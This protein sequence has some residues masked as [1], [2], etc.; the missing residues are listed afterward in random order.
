MVLLV[1]GM[2]GTTFLPGVVAAMATFAGPHTDSGLD[3]DGD[4]LF[5]YLVVQASIDVTE[6]G[7]FFV[8]GELH[9]EGFTFGVSASNVTTLA[10]GLQTVSLWFF[11]PEINASGVDGPYLVELYLN[12]Y[13]AL[14]F[15]AN[16]THTT[17]AYSHLDFEGPPASL[18][19]PHADFGLDTDA[20]GRFNQLVV[21]VTVNVTDAGMFLIAGFLHNANYS[22]SLST[23][24][25][26][27]LPVGVQTVPLWFQGFSIN[28]SG[29]DGPYVVDLDLIDT[30]T[31]LFLDSGTHTTAVYSHLDFEE[32]PLVLSPPHS[33]FGLDT[34]TDGLFD[35]LV[36][37]VTVNVSEA[38]TYFF[39]G[40]LHDP[41]FILLTS[42]TNNT[43]VSVGVQTVRLQFSGPAINASGVDGPYTVDL[44]VLDATSLDFVD[45]GN[46]TTA[47]YGYLDFEG[48][49]ALLAPPHSDFPLDMDADG[50]FDYLAVNVT[51]DVNDPGTY[52]ILGSISFG[53]NAL[54][55]TLNITTLDPGLQ[56]VPLWF[57]GPGLRGGTDGPYFVDLILIDPADITFLDFDLHLTAFYS[58]QAFEGPEQLTSARA[59]VAPTIDGILSTGEWGDATVTDLSSIPGNRV[60]GLL[61]VK[62]DADRVYVAYDITGDT[63]EDL[64][65][66]ASIGFDT[67]N[68]GVPSD[69]REDE[70]LQR[71][72]FGQAHYVYDAL[73]EFWAIEDGP[74]D[75]SLPNHQGLA[76]AVGFGPSE[77]SPT[78]HRAYEFAVPIPLLGEGGILGFFGG[79]HLLP[80]VRDTSRA[81][82]LGFSAWPSFAAGALPLWAYGDLI[83]ADVTPPTLTIDLPTG[84]AFLATGDVTVLWSATDARSGIDRFEV[85]LDGGTPVVLPSPTSSHT[86]TGV[87]DGP[88]SVTVTAFDNAGNSQ[89][90]VV[91]F[92]V[93]TGP[94][95]LSID[96][97]G[98]G[99]FLATRD[100]RVAWTAS[101][102]GSGIDHFEV[103]L[104]GGTPQMLVGTAGSHTFG[105]VP[106]G[107]HTINVTAVDRAGNARVVL[108][109]LTVDTVPPTISITSPVP[110]SVVPSSEAEVTWQAEDA[111]AG[112]DRYEVRLDGGAVVTLSGSATGHTFSGVG[113]GAHAITV[114]AVDRAGNAVSVAVDFTVDTNLLSPTGPL[115]ILLLLAI[116][117]TIAAVAAVV[118]FLWLRRRGR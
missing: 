36:V 11:G 23:S 83:L 54:V 47:P 111:T 88:H 117:A 84:G 33:D 58:T 5:D 98:D 118:L 76:S 70:F 57:Y 50:K 105:D 91:D 37:N 67:G 71:D 82:G 43:D 28:A 35:F 31:S 64:G 116:P 61:Y 104:D 10:L 68:D 102:A 39:T 86:I 90:V 99:S 115:G 45:S 107:S 73:I 17:A 8:G 16:D 19:P 66:G 6:A 46:H 65:D 20:D 94:P 101:D 32:P 38:G 26:T 53:P 69:G 22:L 60:P 78:A 79:S 15:L 108:L 56:I 75:P 42:A 13:P 51:V 18:E 72:I 14:T 3:V 81:F 63:T 74:Y 96:S 30:A 109:S 40:L 114:V 48:P 59:T 55:F 93:D 106:D 100:I 41:S 29:V 24:N 110:D 44:E 25:L 52:A 34:D 113:D 27:S 95:S 9:D 12:D 21:S 112:I 7:T 1:I 49:R 92:T 85:A 62:N 4:G 89:A 77:N 80:G 87:A 97:P 2:W 103:T